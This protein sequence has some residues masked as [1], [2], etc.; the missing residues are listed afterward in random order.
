MFLQAVC[1]NTLT[2]SSALPFEGDGTCQTLA[3]RGYRVMYLT[4]RGITNEVYYVA[5]KAARAM[6]ASDYQMFWYVRLTPTAATRS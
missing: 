3:N 6:G 2:F 1:N 4:A 5:Q